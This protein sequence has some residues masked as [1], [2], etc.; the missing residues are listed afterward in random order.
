MTQQDEEAIGGHG[1]WPWV[2]VE[3]RLLKAW[4]TGGANRKRKKADHSQWR[5]R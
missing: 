1:N 3:E 2:E 5:C 4:R